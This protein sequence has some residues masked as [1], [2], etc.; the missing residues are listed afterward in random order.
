MK[1]NYIRECYLIKFIKNNIIEIFIDYGYGQGGIHQVR[2]KDLYVFDNQLERYIEENDKE[3]ILVKSYPKNDNFNYYIVDL[4][5][6]DGNSIN[7]KLIE[8]GVAKIYKKGDTNE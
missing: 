3:V 7:N 5:D 1:D 8:L 2:L 4:Y 6:L